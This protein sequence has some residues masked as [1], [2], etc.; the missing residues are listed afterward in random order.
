[1]I[2]VVIPAL[3]EAARIGSVIHLAQS[4]PWVRETIVI[5]DGSTDD[6]VA[7]AS[8]A[9]AKVFTSTML[10]KGAS[11]KDGLL[12]ASFDVIVYL[13]GDLDGLVPDIIERLARPILSS[14]ADLVKARFTRAAGRVTTLTA[15]P[16]LSVFFPELAHF[17]QPLGGIIAARRS[18]LERLT[19]E[20]GY[21]VDIG[22]LI[23]S[24][25]SGA[26]VVEADIGH[27]SHQS[28]SLEALGR[29]ARQVAATI[30]ERAQ[31]HGRFSPARLFESEEEDRYARSSLDSL[32][33]LGRVKRLILFDMDGTLIRGRFIQHLARATGRSLLL[34]PW[35]DR[36]DMDPTERAARI[37]NVFTGVDKNI[38]EQ[39]ARRIP[40]V[41]SAVETI[42]ALRKAGFTVGILSDS[43]TIV[44]EIIRRRVFADFTFA[45]LTRFANGKCT[46]IVQ[47]SPLWFFP[48]GCSIHSACKGNAVRH[49]LDVLRLPASQLTA[50]GDTIG[51][52]CM[53]RQAG[54]AVAF[55]PKTQELTR[56]A[57]LVLHRSL[58]ELIPALSGQRMLA[59]AATR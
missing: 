12:R 30:L 57:D 25:M 42:I 18:V 5:D 2:S 21:G 59:L 16:L 41:H 44:T 50:V 20:P 48:H 17:Q 45:N 53:L 32:S 13:D 43:Y 14:G 24:V 47:P 6:T 34:A 40:L 54:F 28:Q 15:K 10:G 29:M 3:N 46:G 49:I 52:L 38:F 31:T 35:L 51:D 4:C 37:A 23:D 55:E 56:A 39:V 33:A 26:K 9:G 58:E 19:L 11:M 7:I 27:L 1:M 36:H 22:I 8:E